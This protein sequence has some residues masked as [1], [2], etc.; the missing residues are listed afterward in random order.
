MLRTYG[1]GDCMEG[2]PDARSLAGVAGGRDH[3]IWLRDRRALPDGL[4]DRVPP[5]SGMGRRSY[6]CCGDRLFVSCFAGC[7]WILGASP[8]RVGWWRV[9]AFGLDGCRR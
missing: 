9:V 4:P 2:A 6:L 1:A 5:G 3:G 8:G 7:A